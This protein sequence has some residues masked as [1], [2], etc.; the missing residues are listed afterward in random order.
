MST[1]SKKP[2]DDTAEAA[3][4]DVASDSLFTEVLSRIDDETDR[5]LIFAGVGLEI[6][7]RNLSLALDL[8]T[9]DLTSRIDRIVS[10]L[11][12]DEEVA[13]K[14]HDFRRA[15]RVVNYLALAYR[16]GLQDWFCAQCGQFMVASERG[17]R[18]KTC[19]D[20]CR[21]RRF[22]GH[23]PGTLTGAAASMPTAAPDAVPDAMMS[24]LVEPIDRAVPPDIFDRKALRWWQPEMRL[25][26]RA[27]VLLGLS[28]TVAL[29][30][31]DIAAFDVDDVVQTSEGVEV[32]LYRGTAR[33]NRY[34]TIPAR[35][36]EICP[37]AAVHAWVRHLAAA[38]HRSGALFPRLNAKGKIL[39]TRLTDRAVAAIVEAAMVQAFKPKMPTKLAVSTPVLSFVSEG[40][41]LSTNG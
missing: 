33:P 32:R 11:R 22:R 31:A 26:D 7:H 9:V 1:R 13:G 34:V 16:L 2:A 35:E 23:R 29:T 12:E 14:L 20:R 30:S 36:R 3:V 18:R 5:I 39:E 25:R 21:L 40:C 27:V 4:G 8:S 37:V 17:R 6:S 24:R 15:G 41:S 19:S 28:C 38:E 10:V